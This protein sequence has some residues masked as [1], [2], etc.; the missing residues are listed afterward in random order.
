L[1]SLDLRR[2]DIESLIDFLGDTDLGGS[3]SI[4]SD[5]LTIH[6]EVIEGLG[7]A[8]GITSSLLQPSV[9]NELIVLIDDDKLA[10]EGL[11]HGKSPWVT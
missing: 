3:M 11:G 5:V 1:L 2:L 10:M 7:N 6:Q 4:V 8:S 9:D